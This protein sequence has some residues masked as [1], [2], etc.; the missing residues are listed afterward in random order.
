MNAANAV[1]AAEAAAAV[2]A[3]API[4]PCRWPGRLLLGA[5]VDWRWSEC[6][7]SRWRFCCPCQR[8][9]RCLNRR[10]ERIRKR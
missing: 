8:M 3:A 1:P 6:C 7:C 10:G 9:Q 5:V 4:P 2:M